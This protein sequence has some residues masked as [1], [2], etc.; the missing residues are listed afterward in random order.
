MSDEELLAMSDE[1]YLAMLDEEIRSLL[2]FTDYSQLQNLNSW[3]DKMNSANK[4]VN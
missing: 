3:E 2:D 4:A 1:E